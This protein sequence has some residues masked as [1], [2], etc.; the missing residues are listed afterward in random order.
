[1]P[2]RVSSCC[3]S[4]D[5]QRMLQVK[6]LVWDWFARGFVLKLFAGYWQILARPQFQGFQGHGCKFS[7]QDDA[8]EQVFKTANAR[9]QNQNVTIAL[10]KHPF[11]ILNNIHS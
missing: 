9:R 11:Y 6:L 3:I 10:R 4:N 7:L 2:L 5:S 1:M 8:V